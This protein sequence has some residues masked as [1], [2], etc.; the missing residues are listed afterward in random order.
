ME[1]RLCDH[2]GADVETDGIQ[3]RRRLFCSDECCEAFEDKFMVS[4]EPDSFDLDD[5]FDGGLDEVDEDS[6]LEGLDAE[7]E[8]DPLDAD[9]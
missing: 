2:C 3:H 5:P 6:E 8:L 9:F 7:E 1:P 4:G